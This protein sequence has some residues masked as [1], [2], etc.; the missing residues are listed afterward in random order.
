MSPTPE[1]FHC[2]YCRTE[3]GYVP[4]IGPFCDN[5]ECGNADGPTL[6]GSGYLGP[7]ADRPKP[8]P[9]APRLP[10]KAETLEARPE[11]TPD[12]KAL[13]IL[14][15][16]F[17]MASVHFAAS[18]VSGSNS[19]GA[20][21][22]MDA[23]RAAILAEFSR[24][25]ELLECQHKVSMAMQNDFKDEMKESARL[26]EELRALAPSQGAGPTFFQSMHGGKMCWNCDHKQ[27][28]HG[29]DL[30]CPT[31]EPQ[32]SPARP[33]AEPVPPSKGGPKAFTRNG[34]RFLWM[35]KGGKYKQ[36]RLHNRRV[37]LGFDGESWAMWFRHLVDVPTRN[38][39]ETKFA[40][41]VEAMQA[42]IYL[43]TSFKIEPA[44]GPG[45]GGA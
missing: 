9:A 3:M 41:S 38:I 40:L 31:P 11:P 34:E 26:R 20:E 30:R 27:Y 29:A 22:R 18:Q 25:T 10:P 19:T 2:A 8:V 36:I 42:L 12:T 32:G 4:G 23:A 24:L 28:Q 1:I 33:D 14:L 17:G 35:K 7:Y 16:D 5:N 21:K 15:G 6:E 45:E 39:Q 44:P 37:L 43:W 13:G